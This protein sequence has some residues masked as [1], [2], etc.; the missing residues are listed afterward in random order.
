M[1][2][3]WSVLAFVV[4]LPIVKSMWMCWRQLHF[5]RNI[6]FVLLELKMPREVRKSPKAM[7][8]VLSAIHALRNVASD[9]AE[10]WWDGEVTR[11]YSLEIVSFGGEV[12]FYIRFYH[13]Q[14]DLV[15]AAFFSYYPDVEIVEV[16]DYVDRFPK[17]TGEM[18]ARGYDLWG[19]ELV[20]AREDAYPIK[21]Y[22]DFEAIEEER[23]YDPISIFLEVLAK[24]KKEEI[25]GIQLV[26]SPAPPN[27]KDMWKKLVEKLRL[28]EGADKAVAGG[29]RYKR[30]I[31]FEGIL[32]HFPIEKAGEGKKE[33]FP[34]AKTF[35]MRTP[36]ETD[37]LKA[38]EE[39]LAKAAFDTIIRFAYLSPKELFYDTFA[40]RGMMGAFN[41]YASLDLNSFV[42]NETISTRVKIWYFPFLFPKIRN[43][44]RKHRL[45]FNYRTRG[46]SPETVA[47][48]LITSHWF[49]WNTHSRGCKLTTRS[50]ATLFHPPTHLVV[51]APHVK[52][53]ESRKIGPPAGLAIY[54]EDAEIEKFE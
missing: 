16:E 1:P 19:S 43:D 4:L 34:W 48:R 54:G 3:I 53:I 23:Q 39:N 6:R 29:P 12:H 27:W 41:Q 37:V 21:S 47:E 38:V 2:L 49:N 13:K 5:K 52:R 40:R 18:Y 7:E 22:L 10:Y 8:Q 46:T 28:K 26:I 20:L 25:V 9:I 17:T 33:E 51:T 15:E 24:L 11:W 45:L 50:L 14:R 30:K 42:R 32:P 35:L 31:E 36:G 44:Y